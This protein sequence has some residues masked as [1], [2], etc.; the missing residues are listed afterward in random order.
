MH[1]RFLP[2]AIFLYCLLCLTRCAPFIPAASK[3]S[4]VQLPVIMYHSVLKDPQRHGKYVISPDLLESD[5]LWLQ[6]H[7]YTTVSTEE[8]IRFAKYGTPL[9]KKPVLLT[10]DDG[11][12]NNYT[13]V[14][15]LIRRYRCKILIAPILSLTERDST[16]GEKNPNYS[17][18]TWDVLQEMKRSGLVEYGCHTYALHDAHR[19]GVLRLPGE[20]L[21]DYKALLRKDIEKTQALYVRH[22]GTAPVVMVYPYGAFSAESE[23][24]LRELGFVASFT[25]SETINRIQGEESLFSL[26]RFLRPAGESSEAYFSR[27]FSLA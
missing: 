20:D 26:G 18:L 1:R 27:I 3:E 10:F 2:L 22:L 16:I 4:S 15:P 21:E 24:F 9:P 23:S 12:Y 17:Y 11:F 5:L 13:Y 6:E 19:P 25:C 14:Y 8:V 7:G